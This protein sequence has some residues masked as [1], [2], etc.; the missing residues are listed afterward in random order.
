MKKEVQH[1]IQPQQRDLPG[2][3][4]KERIGKKTLTI[5]NCNMKAEETKA[6][7][8]KASE[9]ICTQGYSNPLEE[10]ADVPITSAKKMKKTVYFRV[11]DGEGFDP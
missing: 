8:S 1:K 7:K 11:K 3:G 5:E 2:F 10:V 6:V 9:F 4:T